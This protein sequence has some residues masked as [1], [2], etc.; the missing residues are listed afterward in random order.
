MWEK[1]RRFSALERPAQIDFLRALLLLPM[2]SL[3]LRWRGFRATQDSLNL[4]LTSAESESGFAARSTDAAVIARMVDAADRHGVVHPSCLAK[5]LT[6]WWLLTRKG[7][8]AKLRVGIR[9]NLEKFEAHAWI[10]C[11]GEAL[12]EPDQ[13]HTHYASFDAE[14]CSLTV[15]K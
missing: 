7:I 3:S 5:S 14:L 4:L 9:K 1:F 12:N 15:E 11:D 10:E 6:L 13:H 2:V 8:A